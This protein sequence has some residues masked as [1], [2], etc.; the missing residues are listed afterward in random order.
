MASSHLSAQSRRYVSNFVTEC[1]KRFFDDKINLQIKVM[2]ER[3]Y[4]E[5]DSQCREKYASRWFSLGA[6]F[7]K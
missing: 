2:S 3:A 1:P 6:L 5:T 4:V 7:D